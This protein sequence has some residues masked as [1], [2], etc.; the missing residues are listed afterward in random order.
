MN[1]RILEEARDSLKNVFSGKELPQLHSDVIAKKIFDPDEHPE[2][3][4]RLFQEIMKDTSI[5]VRS[6]AKQEGYHQSEEAK[7][8]IA[9]I[10][11]WLMD[12]R[13]IDA[14]MQKK[15]QRF[16]LRRGEIYTSDMLL[17]QY[18]ALP[19]Q[20][21]SDIDYENVR[22]VIL[23]VFM[24]DSPEPFLDYNGRSDRY[25]H[26]FTTMTADSGLSYEPLAKTVYVQLDKCLKQ[27]L[28]NRNA[29]SEDGKPNNLQLLLSLMADANNSKV[30][31][32]CR[33]ISELDAIC[34][35]MAFMAQ[36]KEVQAMLLAEKYAEMD[37]NTLIR[38]AEKKGGNMMVYEMVQDGDVTPEKG[39]KRLNISVTQLKSNMT[40]TGYKWPDT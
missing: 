25:I 17:V 1:E 38:E 20:N 40:N 39:A 31:T 23:I 34:T 21:K 32:A 11:A 28:E 15:G 22:G 18:T 2:R 8:V 10:P 16:I 6:S 3:L 14:E 13:L 29:E 9:D 12:G 24:V 36:D 35:E 7:K 5:G 37:R 27:Y 33:N 30:R 26:R 4:K 19:D